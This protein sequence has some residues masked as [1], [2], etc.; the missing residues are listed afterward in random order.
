MIV[1]I[2]S[3]H[4]IRRRSYSPRPALFAESAQFSLLLTGDG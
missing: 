4:E 2:T 3:E 1:T